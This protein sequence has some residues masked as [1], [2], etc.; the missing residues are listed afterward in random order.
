MVSCLLQNIGLLILITFKVLEEPLVN[1]LKV[2]Q[3]GRPMFLGFSQFI[4]SRMG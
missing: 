1:K 2:E 4:V 3:D